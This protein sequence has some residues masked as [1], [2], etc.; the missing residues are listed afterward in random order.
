MD[1]GTL[2]PMDRHAEG[3]VDMILDAT[4]NCDP[5]V[6]RGRLFGWHAALFPTGYSGLSRINAGAWRDDADGPMPVVSGAI[7]RQWVRFEAPPAARLEAD[8]AAFLAGLNATQD[9]AGARAMPPLIKAGLAHL[10]F[11]SLHPFD[12]GNGRIA[13]W[14]RPTCCWTGCSSG[15]AIGSAGR[16]SPLTTGRPGCSISCWTASKAN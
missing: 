14:I 9:S 3:V 10:W 13:R 1:I 6:T 12:D 16:L 11:V 15:C 2:T 5:P 8:V 7:G 4:A